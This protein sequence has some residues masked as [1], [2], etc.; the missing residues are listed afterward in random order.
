MNY[1]ATVEEARGGRALLVDC[2]RLAAYEGGHIPGAVKVDIYEH[3][4]PDTTRRGMKL[5]VW[6]M[7]EVMRRAGVANSRRVIAYDE[8]SGMCAARLVWTLDWLGHPD[9]AML[10]GGIRGWIASGGELTKE[11]T[12]GK[13]SAWVPRPDP[14]KAIGIERLKRVLGRV[15]IVDT[16]SP[17][18]H[19]GTLVR[20][21]RG[22]TIP[23]A[24]PMH[25]TENC[26]DGKFKP[27][28]ELRA[29]YAAA[30]VTPEKEIVPL[31]NGGYRSAHTYVALRLCGYPR[32]RNYYAA[33][34][35][36]GNRPDTPVRVPRKRD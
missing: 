17:A 5:F 22:G 24:I 28:H 36:W 29:M 33:W 15:T 19:D 6:Q 13:R 12:T 10:D 18:E 2:R 30:G 1:L 8:D 31:C 7:R 11:A 16:R 32:V 34:Q 14:A 23:G 9:A 27:V 4:W 26:R 25:F 21:A 3:H 20:A 35:E